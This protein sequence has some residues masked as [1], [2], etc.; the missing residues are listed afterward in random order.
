[1]ISEKKMLIYVCGS[2]KW[3]ALDLWC[4]Y[5]TSVS[6]GLTFLASIINFALI[7]EKWTFQDFSNKN[8]LGIKSGIGVKKVKVNPDSSF[9]QTW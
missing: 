3:V 6:L 2:S 8:A 4:L 1:M 5:K 9:V 7:I